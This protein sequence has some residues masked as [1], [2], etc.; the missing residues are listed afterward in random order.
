MLVTLNANELQINSVNYNTYK[1]SMKEIN[2]Q[3][4][5][6]YTGRLYRTSVRRGVQTT[7]EGSI[8]V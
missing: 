5:Q 8:G 2:D 3:N 6:V 4:T 1:T 7:A